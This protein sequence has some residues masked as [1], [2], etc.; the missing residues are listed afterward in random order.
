[1]RIENFLSNILHQSNPLLLTIV[2]VVRFTREPTA[3]PLT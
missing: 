3:D 1:M 2:R